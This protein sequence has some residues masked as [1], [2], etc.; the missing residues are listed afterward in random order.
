MKKFLVINMIWLSLV[1][2]SCNSRNKKESSE[3]M[4]SNTSGYQELPQDK[5]QVNDTGSNPKIDVSVNRKYDSLGN[6]IRFDSTYSYF[7]QSPQL[8]NINI[9]SDS[10]YQR[11]KNSFHNHFLD[12]LNLE[13][14]KVFF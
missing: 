9:R 10:L 7:Y 14:N 12:S 8:K 6:L 11:F 3:V 2:T 4:S 13:M 1:I 5:T